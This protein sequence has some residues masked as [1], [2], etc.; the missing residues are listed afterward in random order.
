[1]LYVIMYCKTFPKR[2][3]TN[4]YIQYLQICSRPLW[5]KQCKHKYKTLDK[6]SKVKTH[7]SKKKKLKKK[8]KKKKQP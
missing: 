1:M 4:N 6:S 3:K 5:T 8:K 7:F 2:G